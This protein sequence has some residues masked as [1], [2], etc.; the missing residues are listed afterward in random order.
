MGLELCVLSGQAVISRGS[1]HI[2]CSLE[3]FDASG[4]L[5]VKDLLWQFTNL[6]RFYTL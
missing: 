5:V 2:I 3:L 4:N 1:Y 6:K